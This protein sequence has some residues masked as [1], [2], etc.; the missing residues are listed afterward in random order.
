MPICVHASILDWLFGSK[1][2]YTANQVEDI[3]PQPKREVKSQ[4]NTSTTSIK[5]LLQKEFPD[6]PIMVDIAYCESKFRQF[7]KLGNVLR[8]V[9]NSKDV[10]VFQVNEF[11]HLADSS[12]MGMDIH[13][14]AGN[15]EYARHLYDTQGTRPWNWSKHCWEK[16]PIL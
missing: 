16:N 10:G 6:A 2:V 4:D 5:A 11:Y 9:E 1:V 8:G 12:R 14:L 7:D 3:V 15:I 13:T